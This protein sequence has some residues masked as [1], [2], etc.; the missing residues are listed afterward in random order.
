MVAIH[1]E[2]GARPTVEV[3][4]TAAGSAPV[5]TI[6]DLSLSHMSHIA[7][8]KEATLAFQDLSVE[9]VDALG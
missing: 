2:L 9:D 5:G 7:V 3:T 1:P 8:R 4:D 6:G